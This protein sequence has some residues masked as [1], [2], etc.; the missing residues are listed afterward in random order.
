[1]IVSRI[2]VKPPRKNKKRA[3]I[4]G[5]ALCKNSTKWLHLMKSDGTVWTIRTVGNKHY[6]GEKVR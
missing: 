1:M 3:H 5:G 2:K 6:I 4:R